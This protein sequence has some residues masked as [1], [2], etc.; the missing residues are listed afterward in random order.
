MRKVLVANRGEIAVRAFRAA[1]ELGASTVAVYPYEDRHAVHRTKADEA[2]QIGEPGHPVRA[3]LDVDTIVDVAE[4]TGADAV[5]PG[6]GF[7]AENAELARACERAGIIFVGPSADVLELTGDKSR[8]VAAA[9]AAGVPVLS[10][11]SPSDDVDMLVEAASGLDFPLFVKAVAGGGGRGM[12]RVV[13]PGHE[14]AALREAISAASRE[15]EAAF[16]DG[17][18][19]LEQAVTDPRH[20]EVQILADHTGQVIH[21]FERDCSLQRRH[22]KVIE[23]APA[24]ALDPRLRDRICADA[25]AFARHVGY[26]CAGTV[27][28]L[29]DP[30]GRHVFI[31]MNPRIQVEHTVTEEVTDVDLVSSQL[32]LA[33]GETL[34]DL[35]L[36]QESVSLRGSALQCR[37]TTEDPAAEFRPDTGRITVYR[38]P[39]GGGIRLDGAAH[40][41]AEISGHFDSMLVKLTCRGADH[42]TALR[43]VRR[44]LAEFRIRGV[45]TNLDFLRG[46]LTDPDFVSGRVTTSFIADRPHL[47]TGHSSTNRTGRLLDYLADV[48]VNRPHGARPT[49]VYP[50]DKLPVLPP[51]TANAPAPAGGRQELLRVG[52]GEF[53]RLLRD[54]PQLAVTDTT[55]R[56][57]HQ[58]LLATR[59]R[60]SGLA[61]VA[62]HVGR[63]TPQLW[64][65]ECWGGATYDVALRFLAEDPWERVERLREEVPNIPLQMLLR[66]R[67]T[68]GYTPYPETVTRAF[69]DEAARTGIDVFRIF[70]ALNDVEAMRPAV[71][72]VLETGTTVAEVAMAY[73]GDLSDPAERLYTL[74]YWLRLAEQ[75]VDSG[76]HV[77]AIKDMAGLLRPPAATTLVTA[78]RREFDVPIH[79]HSHDTAGGQL[80]TY[81]AAVT[82]G[83]DAVDGASAPMAG[84]TSQPALSAI[85]AAFAHTDRDT[86]LDLDAV[87][88]LEPYWEA[89]RSVYRPF[90]AA[91][92]G[93]TGRIYTHEIPGGQLSNLR[94]QATELGLA[95]RFEDVEAAYAGANR[96][97]GRPVKVTPSSKVVGDLALAMV[98]A[99]ITAEELEA[100][101]SRM[102][103]PDSVVEFLRG[104][105]GTP[106]GGWP[107]ELRS[108]I[109]SAR[110]VEPLDGSPAPDPVSREDSL[111]LAVSGAP[112][113]EALNRLLFP[114]PAAE[115]AEHR[116]RFGDTSRLSANQFFYG[117]RQGEEHRVSLEEGVVVLIRLEAIGEPDAKGLCTVHLTVNGQPRTV[118][119]RDR[120]ADSTGPVAQKADEAR[121]DHVGAPFSGVVTLTVKAGDPVQAGAQVGTI[122]AMKM[123]API[124]AHAAG[125]V[126]QLLVSGPRQVE[127]GDLLLTVNPG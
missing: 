20:I 111:D 19:F 107:E 11:S 34:A 3:Y 105:L 114:G 41:G 99:G 45:S 96:I 87:L 50:R 17:R 123:E 16:G 4:S 78:L 66:G 55:F 24:P 69:V 25:V 49:E 59:V 13:E 103:V 91:P 15:A 61:A 43:R 67:N 70:D 112:R 60:T 26:T 47:L 18:V 72:A 85:V 1:Y 116:R 48:T 94:A 80:A 44:A 127:A 115:F 122:E 10:S 113:R 97:L 86:G 58:S 102:D 104:E 12:R 120:A 62:G 52:P 37:I 40:L 84:T 92:P 81:L 77:L 119:V 101:P 33:A 53:A 39:G 6:Y 121:A 98:G 31:E 5:Y 38:S 64:S 7:L 110:G 51:E 68:V 90:E 125:V 79:V 75:I 35:G 71:E 100:D 117:L 108:A 28:F 29:V 109:L 63:L 124:T 36:S 14:F 23:I 30:D 57:A 42:Q 8:S 76:A 9:R 27:E 88:A 83:A 21:L 118:T 32:R 126:G 106:A 46:V 73:S 89:L 2:Y 93:P 54:R 95:G 22:Q 82:A 74:D 65:L 56:D